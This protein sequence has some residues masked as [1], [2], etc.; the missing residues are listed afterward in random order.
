MNLT[1]DIG[2]FVFYWSGDIGH[3]RGG[4]RWAWDG[5]LLIWLA[6]CDTSNTSVTHR[7]ATNP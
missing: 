5:V 1:K 2:E 3:S 7:A 4:G 6:V